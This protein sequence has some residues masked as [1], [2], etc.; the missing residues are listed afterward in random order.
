MTGHP[1]YPPQ[2]G[3]EAELFRRYDKR[4]RR[5]TALSVNTTPEIVDDAVN[6]TW[7]QLVAK[8]PRRETAF[9]WL[10]T[11]ARNEAIRL[12]GIARRGVSIEHDERGIEGGPA[13]QVASRLRT[14]ETAQGMLEVKERLADL[15]E[16]LR[17][18]AF[19]RG[20]GWT[21]EQIGAR[22]E[23]THTRVNQLAVRANRHM[24]QMDFAERELPPRAARLD[25]LLTD[26]PAYLVASIGR[27]PLSTPR[28]ARA[29]L[30][31][32]WSRLALAI[33]DYRAERG[34]TDSVYPLGRERGCDPRAEVLRRQIADFR[35]SRG[36]TRGLER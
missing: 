8:Q 32:E 36:F 11:V 14:A 18:V 24:D 22:L 35:V 2:R 1:R 16:R 34:V 30:R 23:V 13:A 31:L 3:D 5:L 25:E 29:E 26:P 6:F 7:L 19:L 28:V 4:L 20:T 12:D 10:K 9:A 15:P 33:E 27:P 17:E 21:Y